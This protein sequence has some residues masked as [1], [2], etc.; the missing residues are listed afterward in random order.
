VK[1][2]F[3]SCKGGSLWGGSEYLWAQTALRLRAM[4]HE[5]T[6][7]VRKKSKVPDGLRELERVGVRVHFQSQSLVRRALR[8]ARTRSGLPLPVHEPVRAWL[9]AEKPDFLCV[10]NGN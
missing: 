2:G 7:S 6:A 1:F 4:G 5:V 9:R 3:L 8:L 10:N